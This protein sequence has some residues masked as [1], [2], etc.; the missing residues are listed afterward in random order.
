M[1]K[2]FGFVILIPAL[3]ASSVFFAKN[4][5]DFYSSENNEIDSIFTTTIAIRHE[6]AWIRE[7][8]IGRN[9]DL[10]YYKKLS[11]QSV[12]PVYYL[13][14]TTHSFITHSLLQ[15]LKKIS[16]ESYNM[17]IENA[18][19]N[20]IS[21]RHNGEFEDSMKF[22]VESLKDS[23]CNWKN[24]AILWAS[25]LKG[26]GKDIVVLSDKK[27]FYWTVGISVRDNA[28][29]DTIIPFNGKYYLPQPIPIN[30][31][32]ESE[33]DYRDFPEYISQKDCIVWQRKTKEN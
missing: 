17:D 24:L 12:N 18:I 26:I 1:K 28:K 5:P 4:K 33:R 19:A 13:V 15:E 23:C 3:V 16:N 7:E 14:D 8:I 10:L 32:Y 31:F 29:D 9:S 2:Y 30:I 6:G 25:L 21:H 11:H 27:G 22:P 20:Y